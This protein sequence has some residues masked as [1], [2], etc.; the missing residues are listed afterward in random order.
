MLDVEVEVEGFIF[1]TPLPRCGSA[2]R[3]PRG[4]PEQLDGVGAG[5]ADTNLWGV[6]GRIRIVFRMNGGWD[7]DFEA[8]E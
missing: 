3:G 1:R 7:E 4:V 5:K 8:G 2:E 6:V